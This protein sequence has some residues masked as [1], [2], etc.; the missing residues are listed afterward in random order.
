MGDIKFK[1]KMT[2]DEKAMVN[3]CRKHF[4]E[5]LSGKNATNNAIKLAYKWPKIFEILERMNSESE[6]MKKHMENEY[7]ELEKEY[8]II[9]RAGDDAVT[10]YMKLKEKIKKEQ[11]N[12]FLRTHQ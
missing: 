9:K 8:E 2:T 6:K 1:I 5:M 3:I 4:K 7:K 10:M 11:K 12:R